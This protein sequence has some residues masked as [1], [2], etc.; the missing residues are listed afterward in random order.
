MPD[1]PW[2]VYAIPFS[3]VGL[4]AAAA[5]YKYLQVRAAAHWPSVQG[6]VVVSRAEVRT[7]Q[8]FDDNRSGGRGSEKRN[9][10]KIVYEYTARGKKLRNDRV[11]IGEDLGNF[12][13]AETIARYPVGSIVTVYYNPLTPQQAVLERDAPKGARGCLIWMVVGGSAIILLSFY[14]FNQLTEYARGLMPNSHRA[15]LVIALS[16]FGLV[17]LLIG[18]AIHKHERQ[19]RRWP[20]V[21]ARIDRSEVQEFRGTLSSDSGREQTLYRPM[22]AFSY[23]HNGL[24]YVGGSSALNASVTANFPSVAKRKVDKFPAGSLVTIYVNPQNPSESMFKPSSYGLLIALVPTAI[25]WG[26]AWFVSLQ[27]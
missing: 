14:G 5:F 1:V 20:K 13:V 21:T 4:I 25:L 15:P 9:F 11:S 10:A 23:I 6:K 3:F 22:I 12:E 2:F 24:N 19:A 17:M 7:V 26:L 27:P 8:T 16:A 18:F